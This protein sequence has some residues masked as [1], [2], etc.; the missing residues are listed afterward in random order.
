[1]MISGRIIAGLGTSIVAT[2]VPLY[3]SEVA[4]ASSRGKFVAMNQIG[5]V[6]AR[7]ALFRGCAKLLR[8]LASLSPFGLAMD[9]ASGTL[10]KALTCN[11]D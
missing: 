7:G 4:P 2:A 9:L 3:I 1:M 10:E 6:S 8:Y 11:G 5:I